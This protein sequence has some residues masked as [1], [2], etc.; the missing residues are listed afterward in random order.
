MSNEVTRTAAQVAADINAVKSHASAI[1]RAALDVGKRSCIEIGRLLLEAKGL[2]PHGEWG[3]WLA[4]N[5]DYSEST[6]NNLMR[7]FK[8]FGDEQID[9][10]TGV[11]DA[12]F[13]SVLNQSQMLEV[14]ALPKEQRRDFV[15]AHREEIES[16]EMSVRDMKAEIA[17]LKKENEEQAEDI[18][19]N[20]ETYNKLLEEHKAQSLELEALK[21]AQPPEHVVQEVIV[22]SPS[23][24]DIEKIRAAEEERLRAEFEAERAKTLKECREEV[25][26]A[27]KAKDKAVEKAEKEAN[28]AGELAAK[29]E[30]IKADHKAAMDKL[31]A[32][33]EKKIAELEASYKKQAKASAVGADPNVVRIQLALENF[34]RDVLAVAGILGKMKAEGGEA[35][36]KAD[37]LRANVE[38]ILGGLIAEAG[39][40]V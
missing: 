18:R 32:D 9:I 7:C 27:E 22:H 35:A 10:F 21:N 20:D 33:H 37:K 40:T 15:E 31:K 8:E 28:D 13:F 6:A 12:D 29:L 1:Y 16:G 4:E 36:Q 5:V 34:K 30:K 39:W 2:V 26:A 17:R 25:A 23:D 19:F 11:S 3:K 38:K 24:E 14:I